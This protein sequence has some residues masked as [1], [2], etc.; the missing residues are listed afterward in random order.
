MGEGI[1]DGQHARDT[2]GAVGGLPSDVSV[3]EF[4]AALWIDRVVRNGE[5]YKG[6]V[7]HTIGDSG[8][9]SRRKRKALSGIL[10]ACV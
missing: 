8:Y 9:Y 6:L 3:R 4:A 10:A 1:I 7:P 2:C 5:G